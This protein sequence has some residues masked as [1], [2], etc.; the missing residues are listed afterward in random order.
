M[1]K[2]GD[3]DML[4]PGTLI[5][6]RYEIV[7]MV[8]S[9]GMAD[10]YKAKCQRLNRYVA[11]KVLKPEYSSD[12]NFVNK[13]KGE[14]QSV[15]GLS[16]PNVV[17]MFD[18]AE[19][20]GLHYIVMELVEGITLK[21]FIERK[22]KLDIREAIGITIQIAQ[23]M[24]AAHSNHI[25]HRD[26]KPQN[27]IISREGK[28]M[29]TDFGIAK[30]TSS[31]TIT[32]NTMGSVHYLS[33]EQAR[34]GYSDEKS[35][36]YSLGIT[37][38]EMLSGKVPFTA[39]NNV[40][41]ALLHIQ[42][43]ALSLREIDPS[44]PV[45][46]DRIV[47]KCMQKK[48]E[49]RYLSASELISDLKKSLAEPDGDFVHIP[50]IVLNDS[51]T[52]NMAEDFDKIKRAKLI[53]HTTDNN[54]EDYEEEYN[55][56]EDELD[57][58]DSKIEKIVFI[59]YV[60]ATII[61]TII[62]IY[63]IGW[64][65]GIWGK[66]NK[67]KNDFNNN[68]EFSEEIDPTPTPED[69]DEIED[70]TFKVPKVVGLKEQDAITL[71]R[72]DAPEL[73]IRTKENYSDVYPEGQV[74]EQYPSE[75]VD[76]DSKGQMQLT[77]SLGSEPFP[78]PS[79]NNLTEDKADK[80][81]KELELN[82]IHDYPFDDNIPAGEVIRTNPE[83]GTIVKKGDTVTLYIS[84]GP[85]IVQVDVPP[86]VGLT[87]AEAEEALTAVGLIKGRVTLSYSTSYPEG[88]VTY[89]SNSVG[90]KVTT[91]TSVDITVSKG[92]EPTPVKLKYIGEVIININPFDYIEDE[93]AEIVL[94]MEQ[95]G[96]VSEIFEGMATSDDFPLKVK[97]VIGDNL[98]DG[99]VRMY[100]DN[101]IFK[102]PDE[103]VGK[104]WKIKFIAVE[105]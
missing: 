27:I 95:D 47:R 88:Q 64:F 98:S 50:E 73:D 97:N 6:G 87:E 32:S 60:S 22:G 44:I 24:D 55:P 3:Y 69:I 33:P 51:P 12:I 57:L 72:A 75:N 105:E 65:F 25:I 94:E 38:Y 83:E 11:I 70:T 81:L 67:N 37:L 8:G 9:G 74:M 58:I 93:E 91:G 52:I 19:D 85:A 29:I 39:D 23:G 66:S 82:V 101:M 35:D 4:K 89:Q 86:L 2:R 48:P 43:E 102:L 1:L 21:S 100:V 96:W 59:G 63:I 31:N 42:G 103:T 45:S 14:A 5:S 15:A 28:V 90:Q 18:V 30:A 84:Y 49:R 34:G 54:I 104:T 76:W 26:I 68:N 99:T 62:I 79:L 20:N 56:E 40:S 7:E 13:F 53:E 71:L 17:N 77:I 16:H 36:I 80:K 46:I 10:V 78:L 41:V 92:V 61:I